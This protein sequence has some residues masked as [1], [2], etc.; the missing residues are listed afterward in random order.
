MKLSVLVSARC[1]SKYLAKF[2]LG[3]V[4]N[5]NTL[6]KL[7][8]HIMLNAHDE[9]N[10]E[11]ESYFAKNY[12]FMFYR[13]DMGL[14]RAG[15]H[16]YFNAMVPNATGDW[17]VYF[18][19]DHFINTVGW[20]S[21]INDVIHFGKGTARDGRKIYPLNPNKPWVLVPKFDNAG[22]MN[23]VVSRGFI[24]A[25]DGKFGRHGWIDS[26]INDLMQP[27]PDRLIKFDDELF[28][29]FTHDKPDPM[30]PEHCRAP[31]TRPGSNDETSYNSGSVR[32]LIDQDRER[33]RR[34]L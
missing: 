31:G 8:V 23:H 12:G 20:D 6:S 10:R 28:H 11:L 17:L 4:E 13:E 2:L 7:D 19:E 30:S 3:L 1:N 32:E 22:A 18:C 14:G 33:L 27:F 26:Y 5:T 34:R 25:M 16:E 15:L 24:K 21:Y 9:W 29:D